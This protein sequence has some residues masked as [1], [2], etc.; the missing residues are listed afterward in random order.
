MNEDFW[1]RLSAILLSLLLHAALGLLFFLSPAVG[2]G[3][4]S[5][6]STQSEGVLIV[7]LVP[8]S[9]DNTGD[10]VQ[11]SPDPLLAPEDD[12]ERDR[13]R[14]PSSSPSTMVPE[15]LGGG[16]ASAAAL[17]AGAESA[18]PAAADLA[19]VSAI[20]YRDLLLAH[21]ARYRRYPEDARRDG[22]QGTALVRFL[23]DRKG[24]V[25]NL[26]IDSSSGHGPLDLEA[27]AAVRRAEPLPPIPAALPERID[28]TVPIEFKIG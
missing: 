7:E 11:S 22:L 15:L 13:P 2:D 20:D 12:A 19:G 10:A 25:H 26:W 9:Q 16:S 6:V 24:R 21:I 17:G 3:G 4:R 1:S 8:L 14:V 23:I 27:A 18:G 5:R 28:I